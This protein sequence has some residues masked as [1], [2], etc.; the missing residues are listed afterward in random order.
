[1]LAWQ[2]WEADDCERLNRP[3]EAIAHLDRLI[4][5]APGRA[6]LYAL[7]GD[8]RLKLGQP[9]PAAD[10]FARA[11]ARGGT[12]DLL[13]FWQAVARLGLGDEKGYERV[14]DD[15]VRRFGETC[16]G[17]AAL[18]AGVCELTPRA[19]AD[20][21]PVVAL[22]RRAV[23]DEPGNGLFLAVLGG[24]LYR[25]GRPREAVGPLEAAARAQASSP[26]ASTCLL[27]ALACAEAGKGS[28]AR[29]HL[30]KATELLGAGRVP[31]ALKP[32][33]EVLRREAEAKVKRAGG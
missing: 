25:A 20:F 5:A 22:A 18:I 27:L 7:R 28:G 12:S 1:V 29:A 30:K 32:A 10:D 9:G 6:D 31:A 3:A 33:L 17:T 23:A 16:P 8:A 24:A 2:R 13:W 15:A 4:A 26:Q 21:E 14:C 11:I 19:V